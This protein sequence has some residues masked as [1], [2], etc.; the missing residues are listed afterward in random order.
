MTAVDFGVPLLPPMAAHFAYGHSLDTDFV[1]RF[2]NCIQ[3]GGLNNGFQFFHIRQPFLLI[4]W[5]MGSDPICPSWKDFYDFSP[6]CTH[7]DSDEIPSTPDETGE[8]S[9]TALSRPK[10]RLS[11]GGVTRVVAST[12][13]ITSE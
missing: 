3:L 13:T 6:L 10:Q 1:Q 5:D 12:R 9:R 11:K 8:I 7:H 4:H 2:L